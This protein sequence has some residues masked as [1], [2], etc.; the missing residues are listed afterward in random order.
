[1]LLELNLTV[2]TTCLFGKLRIFSGFLF[3]PLKIRDFHGILSGQ[4][5][6][7]IFGILLSNSVFF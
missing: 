6:K 4:F 5:F 3:Y 7:I 2:F 1:M